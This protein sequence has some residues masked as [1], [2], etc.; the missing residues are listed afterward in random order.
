MDYQTGKKLEGLESRL[1]ALFDHETDTLRLSPRDTAINLR[2]IRQTIRN[3]LRDDTHAQARD[4]VNHVYDLV[5]GA[6]EAKHTLADM[7]KKV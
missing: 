4:F 5:E 7:A 3:L 2:G 6:Q 1:T